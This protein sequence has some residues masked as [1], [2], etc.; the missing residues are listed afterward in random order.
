MRY[1]SGSDAC[2]QLFELDTII[3]TV[4]LNQST[5]NRANWT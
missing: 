1:F 5:I 2:P 4:A 3:M